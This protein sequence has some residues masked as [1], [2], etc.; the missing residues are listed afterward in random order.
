MYKVQ[1]PC[2]TTMF[3]T[4]VTNETTYYTDGQF[5]MTRQLPNKVKGPNNE[6]TFAK[7]TI[8]NQHACACIICCDIDNKVRVI[9][10]RDEVTF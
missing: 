3:T 5:S 6:I 8:Y 4:E 1:I 9:A 10:A 7:N 2:G